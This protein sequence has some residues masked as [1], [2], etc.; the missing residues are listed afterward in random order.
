M[1]VGYIVPFSILISH[2]FIVILSSEVFITF[3]QVESTM[4]MRSLQPQI[5]AIQKRYAGD[6]VFRLASSNLLS[7]IKSLPLYN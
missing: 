3:V 6:Q 2:Q 7:L 1:I 5:K 4:A